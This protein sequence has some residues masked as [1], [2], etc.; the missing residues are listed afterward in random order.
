MV[1]NEELKREI[2]EGWEVKLLN[3]LVT[4]IIDHRGKTPLKL[5]GD[6]VSKGEGVIALSAK[7]VKDGKLI[8]LNEANRVGYEMFNKWMPEKLIEGDI[9]MTSEAPLGE[10]YL[11]LNDVEYCMSQRLFAIRA[12]KSQVLPIYLY[13]ELSKGNGYS[14]IIGKSSG[15]TVFGIRQDELRRVNVLKPNFDLQNKFDDKV[16]P[17]LFQIRNNEFE[18]QQL[19]SLRDWLLPML[20]NGQVQVSESDEMEGL[21]MAAEGEVG[22]G[23]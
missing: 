17:M 11:I 23:E 4:N 22:Y 16:R 3:K 2:P 21:M 7:H 15:S 20:M 8:K 12:D 1:W 6:W 18:N 5:G 9:L 10:F 19:A 14:Q 13:Y